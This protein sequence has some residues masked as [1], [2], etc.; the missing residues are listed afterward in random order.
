MAY[1]EVLADRRVAALAAVLWALS[2]L[3]IVQ[4]ALLL[5]YLPFVVLLMLAVLGVLRG[6]RLSRTAPLAWAG[7][8]VVLGVSVELIAKGSGEVIRHTI[9]HLTSA[10]R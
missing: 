1:D 6:L 4:S 9:G 10:G 7:L 8:L 5:P 2:P 3:T